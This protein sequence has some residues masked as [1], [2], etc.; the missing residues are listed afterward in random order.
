MSLEGW[1]IKEE[2]LA[3]VEDVSGEDWEELPRRE[4][5]VVF[6]SVWDEIRS[7]WRWN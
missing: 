5:A 4:W 6:V 1:F 2:F 3:D 7:M